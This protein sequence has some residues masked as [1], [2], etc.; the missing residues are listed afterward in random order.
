MLCV[1]HVHRLPVIDKQTGSIAYIL[2]HKRLIKY[3]FIFVTDVRQPTFMRRTPRQLGI[4]TWDNVQTVEECTRV[5][6]H[7]AQ[8]TDDTPIIDA[9][10]MFLQ[11]RVSALP[12]VD[13]NGTLVDIYAKFDVINLAAEG[14]YNHLDTTV[15]VA[16]RKRGSVSACIQ[17]R[18]RGA[19]VRRRASRP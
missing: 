16:L 4:G 3:L 2:T 1:N 18:T 14:A 8:I 7:T 17:A 9:L 10:A 12:V 19:V 13:N 15:G 6:A 5:H 11:R